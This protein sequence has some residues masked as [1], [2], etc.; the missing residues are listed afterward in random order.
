MNG[1]IS[2]SIFTEIK[3]TQQSTN[4]TESTPPESQFDVNIIIVSHLLFDQTQW[5]VFLN[6]TN[7]FRKPSVQQ[8]VHSPRHCSGV[9]AKVTMENLPEFSQASLTVLCNVRHLPIRSSLHSHASQLLKHEKPKVFNWKY[10]WETRELEPNMLG[11][12]CSTCTPK[13]SLNALLPKCQL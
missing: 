10:Q 7:H 3:N 12:W 9:T 4:D 11:K 2:E 13:Q 5:S 6:N 1:P 8:R